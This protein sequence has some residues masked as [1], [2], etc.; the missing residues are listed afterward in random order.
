MN[1]GLRKANI[2]KPDAPDG[3][4]DSLIVATDEES[5]LRKESAPV[6]SHRPMAS[7]AF[8]RPMAIFQKVMEHAVARVST[9]DESQ[10]DT[11]G[12][13]VIIKDCFIGMVFG[14]LTI[15]CLIFL[16]HHNII[17]LQSA[18]NFREAAFQSLNNPETIA[19]LEE[20]SGM[21]FMTSEQY[22]SWQKEIDEATSKME[23]AKQKLEDRTKE[24]ETKSTELAPLE[25]E[26]EKLVNNPLVGLDKY[27][28]EC[29]WSGKTTCDGRADYLKNTYN[30]SPVAAK[31]GAMNTPSCK[32]E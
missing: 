2:K 31:I 12:F 32:K 22:N 5:L 4:E 1:I 23:S 17:H 15:S 28:G 11:G 24:A 29:K 18:H 27:C 19:N 6:T 8:S 10:D 30:L 20:S 14:L 21:K 3:P 13:I 25:E 26:Y 7:A 9:D 16:D